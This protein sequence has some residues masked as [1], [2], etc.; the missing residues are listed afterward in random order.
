M[1]ARHALCGL[2]V[3]SCFALAPLARAQDVAALKAGFEAELEALNSR[4]IE[5]TLAPVDDHVVLFGIFSPFPIE[6]KEGYRQAIK[7]YFGDFESAILTP[8]DPQY[9]IVGTTGVAWG[10]FRLGTQQK[11]SATAYSDGRYMFTYA[12]TGGKWVIVSMHYSLLEP[13]VHR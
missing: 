12:Q 9:R 5:A 13:L 1:G 3:V 4:K 2:L 11:G 6:G 7:D 10:N 8:I